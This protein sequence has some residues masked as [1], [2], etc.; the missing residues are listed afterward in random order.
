MMSRSPTVSVIIPV[1]NEGAHIDRCLQ[2]VIGQTYPGLI[3]ILVVDGGSDDDTSSI[4]NH[5]AAIDSRIRLLANPQRSTAHGLNLGI[6]A[7]TGDMIAYVLGHAVI[8]RDYVLRMASVLEN[9]SAWCAGGRYMRVGETKLQQAIAVATSSP[10]GV[11]DSRHNY[12]TDAGWAETAFPGFWRRE[13]FDQVGRFDPDMLVNEDNELSYRIRRAGG[14]IWY[15]PSVAVEYVPRS[16]L[17]ELFR[18]YHNYA[19]GK[20][21]VLRKHRSGLRWRHFVPAAWIAWLLAGGGIAMAMPVARPA[22]VAG[23]GLYAVTVLGASLRLRRAGVPWWLVAQALVTLH[24]AYGTGLWR[25]L[26]EW[27]FRLLSR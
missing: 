18:Q 7:S 1:R 12:A 14:A 5:W 26:F 24:A 13:V 22:W 9:P 8:P 23:V 3:E 2:A 17:S 16:S 27:A 21:R 4:V 11:G 20:V 15:E 19:R 10:I 6:E 25:G